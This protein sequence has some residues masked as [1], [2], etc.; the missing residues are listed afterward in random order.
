MKI[1]SI[2]IALAMALALCGEEGVEGTI[3]G[4]PWKLVSVHESLFPNEDQGVMDISLYSEAVEPEFPRVRRTASTE[5]GMMTR[6]SHAA[7]AGG[8]WTRG[9][10]RCVFCALV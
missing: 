6:P 4:K 7:G 5:H 8:G 1:I 3:G 9:P 10:P 2:T